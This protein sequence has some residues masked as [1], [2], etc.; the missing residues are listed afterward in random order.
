M[1]CEISLEQFVTLHALMLTCENL[2]EFYFGPLN[3]LG[4]PFSPSHEFGK[5]LIKDLINA[6]IIKPKQ[7]K[8][9]DFTTFTKT[10]KDPTY[11]KVNWLVLQDSFNVH[12]ND[13]LNNGTNAD[14]ILKW[15]RELTLFQQKLAIAEC[16][17]FYEYSLNI[18]NL[19]YEFNTS[20]EALIVNL[21]NDYSVSQ[22]YQIFWDSAKY[23]VDFR[24]RYPKFNKKVSLIMNDACL[25]YVNRARMNYWQIKG[26]ARNVNVPRNM[27]NYVLY[28]IILMNKDSGFSDKV[29]KN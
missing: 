14:S 13:I 24:A 25:R 12:L 18:R 22:C 5:D 29:Y 23:T 16:R 1:G 15:S 17:E 6:K 19:T 20:T 27:I 9:K 8:F 7:P 10:G 28:E 21:L 4:S 3:T 2:D 11:E 26:F